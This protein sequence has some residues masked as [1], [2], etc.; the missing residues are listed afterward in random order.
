M[1]GGT[2]NFTDSR[3]QDCGDRWGSSGELAGLLLLSSSVA[4]RNVHFHNC[5]YGLVANGIRASFSYLAFTSCERA[6]TCIASELELVNCSIFY[7][8]TDDLE[9][10]Q[11][12]HVVLVNTTF[13]R[14]RTSLAGPGNV[15]EVYW[16]VNINVAWQNK[17]RVQH[18]SVTLTDGEGA[19]SLAGYTDDQGWLMWTLVLE[20]REN[21]SALEVKN[22]Y[23]ISVR[24]SNVTTIV[25]MTFEKSLTLYVTLKDMI[26]PYIEVLSPH[27][28]EYQNFTPVSVSGRVHDFE[29]GLEKVEVSTDGR[30]WQPAAS[31]QDAWS[32]LAQLADGNY[33]LL[34]RASDAVGNR[35]IAQV[36]FTIKTKIS[37]LLVASPVEGL[38]TRN[39]SLIVSGS[40]E[41][42]VTI[43]VGG[44]NVDVVN[45]KF[46]ATVFLSEGN[47]PILVTAT[48]AAGNIATVVRSVVLDTTA[49]FIE[50]V[51][52]GNDSYV[53]ADDVTVSG[54]TEP[55][56]RVLV[57]GL[58]IVNSEGRF[59]QSVPLLQDES[60]LNI[61]VLDA[62]G[63]ANSTFLTVHVDTQA[64]GL[65][66]LFPRMG[67]HTEKVNITV[68]G[69][70]EPFS[71]VTAGE[72]TG[73]AGNDGHFSLNVTLL[74]GNNTLLL[75]STDRAGNTNS[76]VWYVVRT[77][78]VNAANSPW[79][80]TGI[81]VA[82][83]L[84]AENIYLFWRYR[85]KGPMVPSAPA[86]QPANASAA[87][88]VPPE[89][90]P[91]SAPAPGSAP[92]EAL[93]VDAPGI[94]PV[95]PDAVPVA[96]I[97]STP[98]KT[99]EADRTETVEMK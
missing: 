48:D 11:G 60:I 20:S 69:T 58:E 9:L 34:V 67:Q 47:N 79:L 36:N 72:F 38:L 83:V 77:R 76:T 86:A 62:A 15:L 19:A 17:V 88:P 73:V 33:T 87:G 1:A 5:T 54:R 81:L 43:Q 32:F 40:T 24:L 27:D 6:V 74:Y 82:A 50:V 68:N 56:A 94:G 95:P 10:S 64:P 53:A 70:T 92:P 65:E 28:G 59:G 23:D 51:S 35:A 49:P 2:L 37:V 71:T 16:Y 97:L 25:N 57:D 46:I 84:A 14:G 4:L 7:S 52:P 42:G 80:E 3:L 66:I 22:P 30:I 91:E 55:G 63:N 41:S 8:G 78:P 12:S 90:K 89:A 29:T 93:P 96:E 75:K 31:A 44:R 61:T 99:R 18:A 85:R 45:G 13:A 98:D 26:P 39:P 21:G